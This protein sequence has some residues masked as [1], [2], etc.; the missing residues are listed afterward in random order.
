MP[1]KWS[2]LGRFTSRKKVAR[3]APILLT[4]VQGPAP[5]IATPRVTFQPWRRCPGAPRVTK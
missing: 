5:Q 3:G 1:R 2:Y 4:V